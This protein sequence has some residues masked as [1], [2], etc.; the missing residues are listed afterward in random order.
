MAGKRDYYEVL[1]VA[2]D[3]KVQEI[4]SAYRRLAVKYHPDKNPGDATAEEKF[5]EAAEAYAVLSDPGHRSRFDRFGHQAAGGGGFGGFDAE[6]FADF[7]DIL[8]DLFGFGT[9]RRARRGGPAPG[10]DLRYDLSL[11]FEEAAFGAEPTLRI[12]RLETCPSCQGGGSAG[13][14]AP[15]TC[16]GCA[17]HGQVRFTQGFFTVARTC[18]RCGGTG[19]I[20]RDPCSQCGGRGR[21]EKERSITVKVPAGVDEGARLRLSGEGEHGS[22]GGPPG[23][24]YVVI[25]VEEHEVFQR[26]GVDVLSEIVISWPKA[27]LGAEIE[28]DTL[29]GKASLEVPSGSRQGDVLAL[30]GKGIP[31]LAG[32][33]GDHHVAIVIDVPRARDLAPELRTQ[34]AELAEKIPD[35]VPQERSVF[36]R[37]KDLFG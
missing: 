14:S 37:V 21:V 36:R 2:R 18:P 32:G 34:I 12:P 28:V 25:H 10:A 16:P 29:H 33:I 27:V 23:D 31:R 22:R 7:S 20:V 1:G 8:G 15:E 4:K 13:G 3:A 5:K 17:G 30:R 26:R 35:A 9:R 19:S 6:V 11:S 24:L